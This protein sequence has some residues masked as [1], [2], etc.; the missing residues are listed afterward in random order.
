MG[1]EG[2]LFW[3]GRNKNFLWLSQRN[4][5]MAARYL[6]PSGVYFAKIVSE[7]NLL[8]EWQFVGNYPAITSTMSTS[9]Q[10]GHIYAG[11]GWTTGK[12][13][14]SMLSSRMSAPVPSTGFALATVQ[15]YWMVDRPVGEANALHCLIR[16]CSWM[17]LGQILEWERLG[18][19]Y[20][21]RFCKA[22]Q[23]VFFW[24]QKCLSQNTPHLWWTALPL[25]L[26]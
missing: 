13:C 8:E 22:F 5:R 16:P 12:W 3:N 14:L 21:L 15:L 23:W 4:L 2:E 1:E 19:I 11:M 25:V 10:W 17:K 9:T 20:N 24:L 18:T 7:N 6:N 26:L